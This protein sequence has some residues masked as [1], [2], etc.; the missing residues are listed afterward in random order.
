M[1]IMHRFTVG[2]TTWHITFGTYGARLHGGDRP[3]VDRKHSELGEEIVERDEDLEERKRRQLRGPP[4]HLT[5]EQ[6][7]FIQNEIPLICERGG[8]TLRICSADHDHVHVLLDI[9]PAIH[10]EKVRRLIKRWLTQALD[11]R[12]ERPKGGSW[13][14]EQGS[15]KVVGDAEYLANVYEYIEKQRT[16]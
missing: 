2:M 8:W 9:D 11:R 14:A 13:W 6:R 3:T 10:G 7:R 15:N 4:I 1:G 12:W 16:Q 5:I